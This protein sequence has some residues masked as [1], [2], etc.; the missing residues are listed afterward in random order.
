MS[1]QNWTP[2]LSCENP[3]GLVVTVNPD[4]ASGNIITG[5]Y[6]RIGNTVTVTYRFSAQVD[7]TAATSGKIWLE[8]LPFPKENIFGT[9][10]IGCMTFQ[11][12]N[13]DPD[14]DVS[15]PKVWTQVVSLLFPGESK[16]RFEACAEGLPAIGLQINNINNHQ[17]VVLLEGT[18]TYFTDAP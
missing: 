18:H 14:G 17:S 11:C 3:T 5:R 7:Y 2:V 12:L 13:I 15:T 16:L 9:Q 6:E 4:P 8:G 1:V 10:N